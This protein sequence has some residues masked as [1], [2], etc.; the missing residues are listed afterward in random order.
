M[1]NH[2]IF[3][4]LFLVG[5]QLFGQNPN[6]TTIRG[7]VIDTSG[8]LIPLA[9]VMLLTPQDSQLVNFT[10]GD[11][12]GNFEFKNV[13]NTTY[14]LKIS[15]V[16]YLP[17][18]KLIA[19]AANSVHDLGKIAI[20]PITSEL[21]EVVIKAAKATLSIRGDTIEYDASSFKVPPGSTVEDL[22]RR[23]PGIEVDAEGN[24]KAA[25]QDVKR[26]FVDGKTFFG[27]D[28]KAATKNLGAETLSKI[29]VFDGKSEQAKLTGVDDGKKEK[30]MNLELKEEFKK[31][32]F[33]KLTGAGG[34][35][36]RWATRGNFNRFGPKQQLSFIGYA[37]NINQTGVNWEDYGEFKGQNYFGNDDNGDFGFSNGGGNRVYYFGDD[38]ND[39]PTNNFDG[40]GFTKNGGIGSNYNFDNKKTKAN[41]SYFYNQS[42]LNFDQTSLQ[43]TFL[44]DS[45][46][47][48][49]DTTNQLEFRGNHNLS[50]KIEQ[51]FDSTNTL[52]LKI[53]T[54]FGTKNGEKS[55]QQSFFEQNARTSNDLKLTNN[56][57]IDTW[58]LTSTAIFRHR[59]KKKG[60]SIAASAGYNNSNSDGTDAIFS[61]NKIYQTPV[62]SKEI[63]QNNLNENGTEQLKSSLLFTESLSKKWFSESFVNFS[64]TKNQVNR[65]VTEPNAGDARNEDLSVYYDFGVIYNRFGT[66]LRYSYSA[67]NI[68][69]GLAFQQLTLNGRYSAD[70]NAPLLTDPI[71]KTYQ[72]WTPN[73]SINYE[74]KNDFN[75][76]LS[77][78]HTVE[79]PRLTD[80]QPIPNVNNPL[81][82]QE[83]NPNLSPTRSHDFGINLNRW[84]PATFSSIGV[85]LDYNV[86]DSRISQ[87][88]T[89]V[90]I[91]TIGFQTISKPI[92]IS[93]GTDLGG[94]SWASFPIIKTKIT[95]RINANFGINNRITF[96]NDLKND[97]KSSRI[98]FRPS[99]TF[100]PNRRIIA[101]I[102][103][104][105]GIT[106]VVY[107][108][109]K[110]QNQ[111]IQNH[112]A[113]ATIKAQFFK[114]Y[115]LE[116][117]FNYAIYKNDRLGFDQKIPTWNASVRRLFGKK[118]R[119]ELRLAAFD[120][121]DKNQYIRQ[122]GWQNFVSR[123]EAATLARYFMASASYNLRGY[124]LKIKKNN[125]D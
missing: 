62:F 45:S 113:A 89:T 49:N 102:S 74:I 118:N 84:D 105:A 125:W 21:M 8:E 36:E 88:I 69:A 13:K 65:Q 53:Q 70:K 42:K 85:N 18:Q 63:R 68:S 60:R 5:F 40:R 34:T 35:K 96:V 106:N 54:R 55:T 124:E 47:F 56:N 12:K 83:G 19:P 38:N 32:S 46:F 66:G 82:R 91:D 80:L 22:L 15:Y 100:T 57:N 20:K 120:I 117:N 31:G 86:Y 110:S 73:T 77:Y 72:N 94:W 1:K 116:T 64:K 122:S 29:Q 71:K 17:L 104:N 58:R 41:V 61:L 99:F 27:D 98:G 112:G 23:L 48:Q 11:E 50:T 76:E 67:L 78:A 6:K 79:E 111:K 10:R 109:Q 81:Y 52:I 33:G 115:F 119:L 25:G 108:I 107:S 3:G 87:N 37:N 59:F 121:F 30:T 123:T 14:L 28:P 51:V 26:V 24:I 16:S 90:F 9:T 114:K 2:F 93:G 44:A 92:N 101:E 103:G 95:A 43:Q 4:I 75:L 7:I 39:T 97:T